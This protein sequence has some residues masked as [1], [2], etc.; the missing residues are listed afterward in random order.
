[1]AASRARS[2]GW[3]RA[4]SIVSPWLAFAW[5]YFGSPVPTSL[6][7]KLTVYTS[8]MVPRSMIV[9][10][11]ARQFLIGWVQRVVTLLFLAG[12]AGII[13]TF[14]QAL[15]PIW[16]T[17]LPA[18]REVSA[19][20]RWTGGEARL[21]APLLWLLLYYGAM[22]LSNVPAF[23]WY[24]LPPWPLFLAI[25]AVGASR[26]TSLASTFSGTPS[27]LRAVQT[28]AL[29]LAGLLGAMH[30]RSVCRDIMQTQWVEDSLRKPLGLW[31]RA[32]VRPHET[33]L[34][35][36]IG[37]VGYYSQRRILDMIGL[38]SPQVIP[39]FSTH[40]FLVAIVARFRPDWLCLRPKEVGALRRSDPQL[41]ESRYQ[42]VRAFN[43]PGRPS[44]FLVYHRRPEAR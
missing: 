28:G 33:I 9:E 1:M 10:S 6:V 21:I 36:P 11:F 30:V 2:Q 38:V 22:Y 4:F 34:L 25:G 3:I 41:P 17:K 19:H 42:F 7:A 35:E 26:L 40:G 32:H 20:R 5:I 29:L 44:D 37:Y 8:W 15:R 43:V 12:A 24:F 27:R 14:F 16:R 31:L 13:L 39:S 18:T 23:P